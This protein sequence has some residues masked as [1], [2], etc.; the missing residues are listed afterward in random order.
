MTR[1]LSP[2]PLRRLSVR[3]FSLRSLLALLVA[4][5]LVAP[6]GTAAAHDQLTGT[7][8]ADGATV[9]EAPEQVV[10]T[11]SGEIAELG[12]QVVVAGP[13]GETVTDGEPRAIGTDVTQKLAADLPAGDYEVTWRVT[14]QDGHPISGTF[15]FE[16]AEGAAE[17]SADEESEA[18]ETSE[19][20]TS[21]AAPSE[22]EDDASAAGE[23]TEAAATDA[24]ADDASITAGPERSADQGGLPVWGWVVVVL[25]ALGLLGLLARTWTRGRE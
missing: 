8:P 14:S 21:E 16:V 25:A 1:P 18:E 15:G 13:D 2:L 23:E 5:L 20:E 3:S 12:A 6:A 19:A 7:E 11:F 9:Q 17:T 10:L 24:A 4:L 22:S